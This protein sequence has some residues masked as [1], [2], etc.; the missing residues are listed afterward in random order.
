MLLNKRKRNPMGISR[1][2][3]PETEATL[4]THYTGRRQTKQQQQKHNTES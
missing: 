3:N 4:G 2:D 1:M